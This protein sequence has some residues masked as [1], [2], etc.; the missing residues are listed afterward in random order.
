M[1]EAAGPSC[2]EC[3]EPRAADGTPACS[4]ARRASDAHRETRTAEAADAEDFAPV[5]IRPF[6]EI[7]VNSGPVEDLSAD[8]RAEETQQSP[9][10]VGS[11]AAPAA[12]ADEADEDIPIPSTPDEPTPQPPSGIV[13]DRRRRQRALMVSGAGAAV[14]VLVTGGII[15]GLLWY[16]SPS[17][18]DSVSGGVRAGLPQERPSGNNP[19]PQDP[20]RTA[21]SPQSSAT[22]T[23]SPSAP[24]IGGQATRT[25]ADGPSGSAPSATATAPGAPTPSKPSHQAPVLRLG[26]KGPEVVELQLRLRQIGLYDGDADGDYDRPLEAA[27]RGYQLTRV[28]LQDESG[29]YGA[30][31]RASLESETKEP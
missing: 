27:V 18:D 14:A 23:P 20:S 4:C 31:T 11:G 15:G 21:A 6:V 7:G 2:P 3:G 5:R 1:S 19:S 8:T 13:P 29:V 26:D 30:A 25:G 22:S 10:S 28:I 9:S 17:R 24:P 16:D 12:P